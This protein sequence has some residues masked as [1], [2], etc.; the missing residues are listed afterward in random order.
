MELLGQ[1]NKMTTKKYAP[2]T[3][4]PVPTQGYVQP[5]GPGETNICANQIYGT[6]ETGNSWYDDGQELSGITSSIALQVNTAPGPNFEINMQFSVPVQSIEVWKFLAL[7]TSDA[8]LWQFKFWIDKK[9]LYFF[10]I[11]IGR[12][13]VTIIFK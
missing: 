5:N 13:P 11:F 3:M 10:A 7:P 8:S 1:R 6:M 12:K 2:T 9:F 4:A